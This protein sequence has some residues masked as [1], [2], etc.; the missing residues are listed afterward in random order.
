MGA[1]CLDVAHGIVL[2][3]VDVQADDSSQRRERFAQTHLSRHAHDGVDARVRVAIDG[4][5]R[6]EFEW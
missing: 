5:T 4:E 6:G 2:F 3:D 1:R